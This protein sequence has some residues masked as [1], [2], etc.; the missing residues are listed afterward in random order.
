[1]SEEEYQT[2]NNINDCD[3]LDL[4]Y[5]KIKYKNYEKSINRKIKSCK[6]WSVS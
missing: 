6:S 2:S 4:I 3:Y 5:N 1:M